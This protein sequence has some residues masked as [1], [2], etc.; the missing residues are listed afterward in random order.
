MLSDDATDGLFGYESDDCST[1]FE[2]QLN[3]K[4]DVLPADVSVQSTYLQA[5]EQLHIIPA[6]QLVTKL[7]Q[8]N[9]S[10]K[11]YGLREKGAV[12]LAA[13]LQDC[14][15]VT[16][17][18]LEDNRIGDIGACAFADHLASNRFLTSLDLTNNHI[19]HVGGAAV[20][21]WMRSNS[22]LKVLFLRNNPIGNRTVQRISKALL[23]NRSL[24]KL[25]L[26]G[27]SM[28]DQGA[29]AVGDLLTGNTT[30]HDLDLS[31]NHMQSA[32]VAHV[33]EGL[34]ANTSL[35]RLSLGWNG[36]GDNGA[37]A[38]ASALKRNDSLQSLSL[39]AARIGSQG[40]MALAGALPENSSLAI[41]EVA[42]NPLLEA[43]GRALS[44]S[45]DMNESLVYLDI[46][47]CFVPPEAATDIATLLGERR[48]E[49]YPYHDFEIDGRP[50]VV[51]RSR[52]PTLPPL[53]PSSRPSTRGV[54]ITQ[55]IPDVKPAPDSSRSS[56]VVSRRR[57]TSVRQATWKRAA[58]A[59]RMVDDVSAHKPPSGSTQGRSESVSAGLDV[60][61]FPEFISMKSQP[62]QEAT[63]NSD[64][65][66]SERAAM[67]EQRLRG[68][69]ATSAGSEYLLT[70]RRSGDLAGSGSSRP[71]ERPTSQASS[72]SSVGRSRVQASLERMDSEPSGSSRRLGSG[73]ASRKP[74]RRTNTDPG[75]ASGRN[76]VTD[77][78]AHVTSS[79]GTHPRQRSSQRLSSA[80]GSSSSSIS[81]VGSRASDRRLGTVNSA[82]KDSTRPRRASRSPS[83]GEVDVESVGSRRE[84]TGKPW[85]HAG[86]R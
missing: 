54:K 74:P 40:A 82:E 11:H 3:F 18:N 14:R 73:Q 33:C 78:G 85:V 31:W 21:D 44:V 59:T 67:V 27:I 52:T 9:V 51:P 13:A 4:D 39:E 8:P 77:T 65:Q 38:I 32:G 71:G 23:L 64:V 24:T 19:G 75:A 42:N 68:R 61:A 20:A 29:R 49:R 55:H 28:T 62:E 58:H 69:K 70:G 56:V 50:L 45:L 53:S 10:L 57:D 35:M 48:K 37:A 72:H 16:S 79:S 17:L 34:S 26:S 5:C 66:A 6:S 80:N 1:V 86:G 22:I 12:A 60:S 43:G 47:N 15:S 63:T 84:S 76:V 30:L 46:R 83:I 36:L 25:D 41:L 7:A 81:R 2:N